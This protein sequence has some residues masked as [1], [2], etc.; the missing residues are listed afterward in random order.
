MRIGWRQGESGAGVAR[1]ALKDEHHYFMFFKFLTEHFQVFYAL[2]FH[3]DPL[4]IEV[5]IM[6][7]CVHHISQ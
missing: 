3:L 6:H 4:S 7:L 5:P 2:N 1:K